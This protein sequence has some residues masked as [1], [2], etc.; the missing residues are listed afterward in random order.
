MA[1]RGGVGRAQIWALN[2]TSLVAAL[3][4]RTQGRRGISTASLVVR[5]E[6]QA[7][8]KVWRTREA[9]MK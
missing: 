8:E 5:V 7:W 6:T 1:G 4:K 9:L 2:P 3:T